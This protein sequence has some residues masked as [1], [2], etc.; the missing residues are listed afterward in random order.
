VEL[1]AILMKTAH[2]LGS[3]GRD[4]LFGAGAADAFAAVQAAGGN[5]TPVAVSVDQGPEEITAHSHPRSSRRD[6]RVKK[7]GLS[8]QQPARPLGIREFLPG[9]LKKS[10]AVL[11]VRQP[12]SDL[13]VWER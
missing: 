4:D 11:N 3:P 8:R 2:D 1:R 7:I 9:W 12:F 5:V 10:P 13:Y 6:N